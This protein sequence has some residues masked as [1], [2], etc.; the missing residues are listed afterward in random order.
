MSQHRGRAAAS[1]IGA[2]VLFGTSGTTKVLAATGA[3][4]LSVAAVRTLVGAAGLVVLASRQR[5]F[6]RLVRLW[7]RPL[8]WLMGAAV[9]GY[10]G[11]FF[12][13]VQ[14][15]GVAIASLA[16]VSLS[17]FFAALFA[18]MYGA[19]W[20]GRAW[21]VSTILAIIGVV[22]L[23]WQSGGSSGSSRVLRAL[24]AAAAGA[25][26][27]YY[28]AVSAH[29]VHDDHHATDALAASF[30]IGGLLML[31]WLLR[32][33]SWLMTPRGFAMAVWLGIAATTVSYVLFGYAI[34]HLAPGIVTTLVLSE[35]LTATLLG[36]GVLHES[37][38]VRGWFGCVCIAGGLALTAR[39]EIRSAGHV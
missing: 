14:F 23:G 20:P 21:L 15:G 38:P 17:P 16:S 35:P 2:G 33:S 7:R 6:P 3:S 27:S 13:S 12:T 1:A 5:E 25:S 10:M 30:T 8:T 4:S 26:Y 29:L 39:H 22:L 36:V 34:T 32:D 24:F 31:P 11:L 28:T 9:A 37:M 18:R 19:P